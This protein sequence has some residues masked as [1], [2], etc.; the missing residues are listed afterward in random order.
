MSEMRYI[1]FLHFFKG[2]KILFRYLISMVASLL[3]R[4]L[5]SKTGIIHQ[6][7]KMD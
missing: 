5:T 3:E 1:A 2:H 4:Q 7:Q 6:T